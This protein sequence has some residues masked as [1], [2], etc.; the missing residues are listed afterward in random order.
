MDITTLRIAAT[1]ASLAT[2]VG[3]WV[4]AWRRSNAARFDA[5]A[6]LPFQ[7]DD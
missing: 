6:R 3:I 4:W 1:V 2:F 5:A 7:N